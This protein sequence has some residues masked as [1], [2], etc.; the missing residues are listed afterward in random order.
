MENNGGVKFLEMMGG[1]SANAF[2]I[3]D[4][5]PWKVD[6]ICEPNSVCVISGVNSAVAGLAPTRRFCTHRFLK[7]FEILLK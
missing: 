7:C 1:P 4:R 6:A 2:A 3:G 5:N